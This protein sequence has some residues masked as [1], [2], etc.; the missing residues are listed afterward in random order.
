MSYFSDDV[1]SMT[2]DIPYYATQFQFDLPN[3][4]RVPKVDKMTPEQQFQAAME[5]LQPITED[6]EFEEKDIEKYMAE[7]NQVLSKYQ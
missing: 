4:K 6:V 2:Y 7:V 5:I 1:Y 3:T